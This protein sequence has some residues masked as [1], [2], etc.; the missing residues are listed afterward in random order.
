MSQ[1]IIFG[2]DVS[3]RSSTVCVVIDRVKQGNPFTITNDSLKFK[4][5]FEA[6]FKLFI[7]IK[8]NTTELIA[9][10]IKI[11]ILF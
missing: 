6:V 11:I 10:K 5:E 1:N 7:V 2:I 4:K 9:S 3:S 8:K